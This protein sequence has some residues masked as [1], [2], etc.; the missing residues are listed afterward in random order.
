MIVSIHTLVYIN[1]IFHLFIWLF[2]HML[3]FSERHRYL[4]D[5]FDAI[6]KVVNF[7]INSL[8]LK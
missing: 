4:A 6:K 1:G 2:L 3:S 5:Q 8:T 7:L